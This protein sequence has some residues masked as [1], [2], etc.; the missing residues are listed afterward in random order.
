MYAV[1]TLNPKGQATLVVTNPIT[2]KTYM[3]D[4]II[5]DQNLTAIIGKNTSE[6]NGLNYFEL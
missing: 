1:Y 4:F 3:V 5:V 2:K 6:K